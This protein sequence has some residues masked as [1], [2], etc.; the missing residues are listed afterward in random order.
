[1]TA[2][3]LRDLR[4]AGVITDAQHEVL[5]LRARGFSHQQI[6]LALDRSREA[7]RDRERAGIRRIRLHRQTR[8]DAA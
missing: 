5:A 8:K 6:A 7:I 1:M 3:E 4:A 2:A